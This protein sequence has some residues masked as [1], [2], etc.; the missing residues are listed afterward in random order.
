MPSPGIV[1]FN[2]AAEVSTDNFG[3]ALVY[4]VARADPWY[5]LRVCPG[6]GPATQILI[7]YCLYSLDVSF[8]ISAAYSA[9]SPTT[10]LTSD[11]YHSSFTISHRPHAFLGD[12]T[13]VVNTATQPFAPSSFPLLSVW[14]P[15]A[16]LSVFSAYPSPLLSLD[17]QRSLASS[18]LLFCQ[19]PTFLNSESPPATYIVISF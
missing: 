14:L 6:C 17:I 11:V 19:G 15:S 12:L 16:R 3:E 2:V 5:T 18:E 13:D 10:L 9:F 1:P 4:T 8:Q 7:S